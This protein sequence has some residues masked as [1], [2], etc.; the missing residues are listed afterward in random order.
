MYFK[1]KKQ[2]EKEK[3]FCNKCNKLKNLKSLYRFTWQYNDKSKKYRGSKR[4]TIHT[5]YRY[6]CSQCLKEIIK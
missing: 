3:A 4:Y 1:N 5:G 6:L 2:K